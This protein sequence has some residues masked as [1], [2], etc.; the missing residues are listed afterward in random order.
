MTALTKF[1][2]CFAVV[3]D[4]PLKP[5]INDDLHP[6]PYPRI[7]PNARTLS[8]NLIPDFDVPDCHLTH[9][10]MQFGQIIAHDTTLAIMQFRKHFNHTN[11]VILKLYSSSLTNLHV[12]TLSALGHNIIS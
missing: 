3:P 10:F 2:V 8:L 5:S 4:N 11:S 1:F 7:L 12:L 6:P 9:M